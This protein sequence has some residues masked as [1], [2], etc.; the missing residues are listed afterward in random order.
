MDMAFVVMDP[1]VIVVR[2]CAHGRGPISRYNFQVAE[3][4]E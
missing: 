4:G 3:D 2:S 1:L